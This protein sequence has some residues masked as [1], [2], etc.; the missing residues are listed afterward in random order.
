MRKI[1]YISIAIFALVSIAIY[2]IIF[3]NDYRLACQDLVKNEQIDL[4]INDISGLTISKLPLPSL[5]IKAVKYKNLFEL[6]GIKISFLPISLL[7]FKPRISKVHISN[8]RIFADDD[9]F[10]LINHDKI[11][12]L[13]SKYG[14]KVDVEIAYLYLLDSKGNPRIVVKDLS[15]KQ[16]GEM[17]GNVDNFGRF[18]GSLTSDKDVFELKV[19]LI[20]D[21]YNFQLIERYK[22]SAMIFGKG[23]GRI[24]NLAGFLVDMFPYFPQISNKV[25]HNSAVI[26]IS[27]DIIP[28]KELMEFRNLLISSDAVNGSGSISI[29]QF[30]NVADAVDLNFTKI[31][32]LPSTPTNNLSSN[33]KYKAGRKFD[34]ANKLLNINIS[35]E[36]LDLGNDEQ[37]ENIKFASRIESGKLL[38]KDFSGK[39]GNNGEFKVNGQLA[40]NSYRNLFDGKIYL[41]HE[42][43]SKF[44]VD[45]GCI[46]DRTER[47]IPFIL[48]SD[49]RST[50]IDTYLQNIELKADDFKLNGEIS[51]KSI[52]S[53]PRIHAILNFSALNLDNNEYPIIASVQKFIQ[54]LF[55]D[56]NNSQYLNKFIPIRTI[57]YLGNFDITFNDLILK[58]TKFNKINFSLITAP[59]Q[60]SLN[61]L[62]ASKDPDHI[63][64]DLNLDVEGLKPKLDVKV[65]DGVLHT[66]LLTPSAIIDLRNFLIKSYSLDKIILSLN[67]NL[68]KLYQKELEL[69][70]VQF[71]IQS[72]NIL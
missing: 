29:N 48:T 19:K 7:K 45:V 12:I 11:A 67:G 22:Q 10:S 3:F 65:K 26:D 43:L 64:L 52:G 18:D 33:S 61:N 42:N 50:I 66:D 68:S 36:K 21:N 15:L 54:N 17:E 56:V 59:S 57:S 2:S 39:I 53:T 72:K 62:Y 8:I 70:D 1:F 60:I 49:L 24:K 71:Q 38:I 5:E 51:S 35:V 34:F 9:T 13:L 27:F 41:K 55:Q 16:N 40:Q 30:S 20:N 37:L 23:E 6:N 25:D 4:D 63:S 47:A 46:T 31:E 44:L 32:L 14:I 69:D 58:G 28:K